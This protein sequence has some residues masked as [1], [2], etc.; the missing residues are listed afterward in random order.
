[1]VA[2]GV[3]KR[4]LRIPP[5]IRAALSI[6]GVIGSGILLA[7]LLTSPV[8]KLGTSVLTTLLFLFLIAVNPF[9]AFSI[10][11][12]SHP[13]TEI[14]INIE[15]G[16]GI[17]DLSLARCFLGF[18]LVLMLAQV[19]IGKRKVHGITW[20]EIA[21]FLFVIGFGASMVGVVAAST[22]F[23]F[24]FDKWVMPLIV[25]FAV[26]NLVTDRQKLHRLLK[27]LLVIGV[28]S[29]IYML[30]ELQT[31]Y[32]LFF[33]GQ[34][35]ALYYTDTSLRIVRGLYGT[36][37]VFGLLFNWLLPI[38]VYY[39]LQAPTLAKKGLY[40][41]A[42]G[43]MLVGDLLTYKRTTWVALLASFLLMQQFYPQLRKFFIGLVL[44]VGV[45]LVFT[46]GSV[47]Q[48]E[49]YTERAADQDEWATANTRT[50]RWAEGWALW[51]QK[52]LF[53]HGFRMYDRLASR[54]NVENDYLSI[55]ASSG[56]VGIVPY[57]ALYIF[58]LADSIKVYREIGTNQELFVDRGLM[59]VF[60]GLYSTY[61][62]TA[63]ASSGNDGHTIA[64]L[65]FFTIIGA[66]VGSQT[67]RL[68]Q[69]R[70]RRDRLLA[71]LH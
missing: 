14:S 25:Y 10:W 7:I 1:M 47:S 63:M 5:A 65:V 26:R 15:L 35:G 27:L 46:W 42:I 55:M 2:S 50:D 16:Q 38:A 36:T 52:P 23:Q 45:V 17:P 67:P 54:G 70:L 44:L 69:S 8:Q 41:L 64:N 58:I 30:Y 24:L 40:G 66:I 34:I 33:A 3:A 13:F 11:L 6:A 48:S 49:L 18:L 53:G 43:L 62:I 51:L 9:N 29:A 22:M 12:V 56:L 57:L 59:V 60:W 20:V 37:L 32:V 4:F 61:F 68:V 31:G 21:L 71:L 28:Y 19:A 39:F